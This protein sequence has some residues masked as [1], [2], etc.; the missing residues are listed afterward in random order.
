MSSRKKHILANSRRWQ[1]RFLSNYYYRSN[2]STRVCSWT[3][4]RTFCVPWFTE[5]AR[6]EFQSKNV[7]IRRGESV[8]LDCTVIGDNPIEVQWMHN[9]DRLDTNRLSINQ[10]KTEHGLKSQL[11]IG[12]SDRQDSGAYR[13]TADNAYGRSEHLIYLAVQGTQISDT[14]KSS[15]IGNVASI[16]HSSIR[17]YLEC[18]ACYCKE[19]NFRLLKVT[20][21]FTTRWSLNAFSESVPLV[22]QLHSILTW[23]WLDS[24]SLHPL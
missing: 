24:I 16:P 12:S 21:Y 10:M 9:N 19:Q 8:T 14:W 7:T 6:F 22:T 3:S 2:C 1:L 20:D 5:P 18:S 13:C 15:L 17:S 4:K 11:S 23:L